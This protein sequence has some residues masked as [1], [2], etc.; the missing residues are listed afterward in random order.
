M[1]RRGRLSK[2]GGAVSAPSGWKRRLMDG[3]V[4]PQAANIEDMGGGVTMLVGQGRGLGITLQLERAHNHA[5]RPSKNPE[6]GR[7]VQEQG[8]GQTPVVQRARR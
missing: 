5:T 6:L 2:T 4:V 8:P 1:K 7:Q 3:D